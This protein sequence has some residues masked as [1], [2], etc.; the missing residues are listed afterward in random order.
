MLTPMKN[1]KKPLGKLTSYQQLM[2]GRGRRSQIVETHLDYDKKSLIP[3]SRDRFVRR[4]HPLAKWFSEAAEAAFDAGLRAKLESDAVTEL[5]EL[6]SEQLLTTAAEGLRRTL[7]QRPVRGHRIMVVDSVG[8]KVSA[9]AIVD[10]AGN[11]LACDEIQCSALA[12][13]VEQNVMRLGELAHKYKVTLL[14]LTN[15]PA[16]RFLVHTL[17]E[18][19]KQSANSGLRW[20][21][22][23]RSGADAYAAGRVALRELSAFNRRD[24]AAI[25]VARS[26]QDPLTQYLKVGINRIRLGSY[27]RELPQEPLKKLVRETIADCVASRGVDVHSASV[28]QLLCVPGITDEQAQ[29]IATLAAQ[30]GIESRQQL[31]DSV[32]GWTETQSRQ[33]IGLLRVFGSEQ[34]FDATCIH[35]EDYRLAQRLV[36]N[37]ELEIP[38]AAPE[39]WTKPDPMDVSKVDSDFVVDSEPSSSEQPASDE[40]TGSSI[41]EPAADGQTD[42]SNNAALSEAASENS[43]EVASIDSEASEE[44]AEAEPAPASETTG[45]A[46]AAAVAE[47]SAE[48]GTEPADTS[49]E[50]AISDS[51]STA[52][53]GEATQGEPAEA[54]ADKAGEQT[55]AESGPAPEYPEDVEAAQ[56]KP[57]PIDVEKL[58]RGWQVGR[59]KLKSIAHALNEPFADARLRGAPVP[60]RTEMP[61]L[62]NLKQGTCIWAVVVG[63]ADFGIFVELGPECSGLIHIS[64]LSDRFVDDPHE[65]V[66]VGDL[67]MTWVVSVDEKKGR[68]ALTAL[69][70]QQREAQRSASEGRDGGRGRDGRG[71]DARGARGGQREGGGQR[72]RSGDRGGNASRGPGGQRAGSDQRG[73]GNRGGGRGGQRGPGRGRDNRGGNRSRDSRP[74]KPVIVKSKKPVDPISS[75]MKEGAEPLRSFSDLLQFY[76]A[77][78]TDEPD[79]KAKD[80]K[81]TGNVETFQAEATPATPVETGSNDSGTPATDQQQQRDVAAADTASPAA[82]DAANS[83]AASDSTSGSATEKDA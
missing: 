19:M 7:M 20:T 27:Q 49:T 75:A 35:P 72:G 34:T 13:Q 56:A 21:M 9:V 69:S 79:P 51:A 8:P 64:R 25:W 43:A 5:E 3:L 39:G 26:L 52:P 23:D 30:G 24:R 1:L 80:G 60:L 17:R 57:L 4:D 33:A 44:S 10:Q 68:V 41:A 67:I 77:K 46:D 45:D 48:A 71:G 16:R 73:G 54:S 14:A 2:L 58:A 6:A 47:S 15:G 12:T 81:E 59:E 55:A 82:G 70:P 29:Q 42:D 50:A 28:A 32:D 31:L 66:Q 62:E 40:V 36:D 61:S 22:A 38:P 65:F 63:V 11:V 37:T 78:R 76:D 74:S 83:D 53:Q 18:L